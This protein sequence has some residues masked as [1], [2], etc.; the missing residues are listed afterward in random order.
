MLYLPTSDI[1]HA[2]LL[3]F[4]IETLCVQALMSAVGDIWGEMEGFKFYAEL[5]ATPEHPNPWTHE[6]IPENGEPS[7]VA[8]ARYL[9]KTGRG[10]VPYIVTKLLYAPKSDKVT[11]VMLGRADG[12]I[13]P[14][15]YTI[16]HFEAMVSKGALRPE[17]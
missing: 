4:P 11:G 8:G 15:G 17:D 5:Y 14:R 9:L 2:E 1:D 10:D 3:L 12:T 6:Y 13:K 7:I 16:A